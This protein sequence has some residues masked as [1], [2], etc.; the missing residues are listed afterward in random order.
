M[1]EKEQHTLQKHLSH[2][3]TDDVFNVITEE[4]LLSIDGNEWKHQGRTLN[5]TEIKNLI[6]QAQ[7]LE[8]LKLW[9]ILKTE[10]KHHAQDRTANKSKTEAD[11]IAGRL[12]TYIVK[13]LENRVKYI[14][15]FKIE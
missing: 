1:E 4:D 14:S 7:I 11:L 10:L 2:F 8:K 13:L 3:L 5:I 9:E 15:N 12:M 6:Q